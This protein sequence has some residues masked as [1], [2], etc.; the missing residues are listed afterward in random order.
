LNFS[1]LTEQSAFMSSAQA[2][3]ASISSG[4]SAT[5]EA[6]NALAEPRNVRTKNQ[7]PAAAGDI[8]GSL[9]FLAALSA[10]K[11]DASIFPVIML[12]LSLK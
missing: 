8:C 10:R 4:N 5:R 1:F 11:N 12:P 6:I 7:G 3:P 9:R 2:M